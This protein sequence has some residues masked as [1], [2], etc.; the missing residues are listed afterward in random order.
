MLSNSRQ[1]G[2]E[3]IGLHMLER[4][5]P[6]TPA[7]KRRTTIALPTEVL[8]RYAG[9]YEVAGTRVEVTASPEGLTVHS[10][11]QPTDRL[12]PETRTRFVF[13]DIDALVTFR[14]DVRRR[15]TGAVLHR[16]GQRIPVTKVG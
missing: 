14:L 5:L 1:S 16:D 3:D 9:V 13:E 12:Y 4:R 2:V 15:V 7:R 8:E 11:G 6:L 10:P